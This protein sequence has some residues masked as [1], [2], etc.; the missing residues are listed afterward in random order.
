MGN[1][2]F[3]KE[4]IKLEIEIERYLAKVRKLSDKQVKLTNE[5][6]RYEKGKLI[7]KPYNGCKGCSYEFSKSCVNKRKRFRNTFHIELSPHCV[8][9]SF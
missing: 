1:G 4:I 7:N 9:T 8:E 2:I 6:S 5:R 3:D